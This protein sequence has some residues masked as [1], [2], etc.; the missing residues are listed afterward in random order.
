MHFKLS[1]SLVAAISFCVAQGA[2]AADMPV[3]APPRPA[4]VVAYT[5]TGCYMG[6]HVGGLWGRTDWSNA[7]GNDATFIR[8]DTG[9]FDE[10]IGGG[11]IGCNFQ[12]SNNWVI[13]IEGDASWTDVDQ[14]QL[15]DI[16]NLDE[17]R[18]TRF[19]WVAT[20]RGRFGFAW[21]RAFFYGTGGAAFSQIRMAYENYTDAT[22]TV[23]EE[24]F[25]ATAKTGWVA[26]AGIEYAFTD[27]WIARI[28]YLHYDFDRKALPVLLG[29]AAQHGQTDF[30]VVRAGISYKF[31]PRPMV[32]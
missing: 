14:F 13:G 31:G 6:G 1:G 10:I 9:K 23:L 17:I 8:E 24:V 20:V 4:A 29:G 12:F 3:K 18:R 7:A 15:H 19:D 11:H 28:E 2:F 25:F 5:W 21:N 30:D 16:V 26:G 27:N 32:P 22:R